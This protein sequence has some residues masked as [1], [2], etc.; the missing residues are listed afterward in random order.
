MMNA[1]LVQNFL[2]N[3]SMDFLHQ[4]SEMGHQRFPFTKFDV[5]NPWKNLPENFGPILHSSFPEK[6]RSC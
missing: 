3:F 5:K 4:I 2:A 1:K 6:I